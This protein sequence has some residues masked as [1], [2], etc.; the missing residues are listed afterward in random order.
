MALVP[1]TLRIIC[2]LP[3]ATVLISGAENIDVETVTEAIKSI[4]EEK[5]NILITIPWR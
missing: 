4:K 2:P 5:E 3:A 1:W